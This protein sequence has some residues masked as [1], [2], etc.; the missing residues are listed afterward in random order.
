ML[1][2][3]STISSVHSFGLVCFTTSTVDVTEQKLMSS[4]N[5]RARKKMSTN[6][7]NS[8]VRNR[9]TL[10]HSDFFGSSLSHGSVWKPSLKIGENNHKRSDT[11]GE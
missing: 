1:Y 7:L 2:V 3:M 6:G 4:A 5:E 9:F 10:I 11:T 8:D